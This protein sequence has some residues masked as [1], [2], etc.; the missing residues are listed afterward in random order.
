MRQPVFHSVLKH[1]F[2]FLIL[3]AG[4]SLA[5]AYF[6]HP[7]LAITDCSAASAPCAEDPIIGDNNLCNGCH[8]ITIV[9]GNRNGTDRPLTKSVASNRHVLDPRQ[10][11][12]RTTVTGMIG[13]GAGSGNCANKP[14]TEDKYDCAD[15]VVAYLNTNYSPTS[16]GP[17]MSSPS[18]SGVGTTTATLGWTT[19]AAATSCVLYGTPDP[20]EGGVLTGDTCNPSDP[21]YDANSAAM[22]QG[23]TVSLINLTPNTT[24]YAIH[25]STSATGTATFALAR[26]FKTLEE[27]G[28][29]PVTGG[30]GTIIS[31]AVGDYNGDTN[32]DLG[33]GVSIF[34]YVIAYL[35]NGLG[36][37]TEGQTLTNVGV[38]PLGITTGGVKAD[39]DGDNVADLAVANFGEV[40]GTVITNANVAIFLGTGAATPIPNPNNAFATTPVSTISLDASATAVAA[41]D[42]NKD[43][44]MDVAVATVSADSST[45]SV[46][47]FL[48][49]GAGH[50]AATPVATIPVRVKPPTVTVTG[51][52]PNPDC[53]SL[54]FNV[55]VAGTKL[56]DSAE[57]FLDDVTPLPVI[58]FAADET[59]AVLRIPAGTTAGPHTIV[60]HLGADSASGTFTVNPRAV[61][62][63]SIFPTS[64]T[65]GTGAGQQLT[66]SGLGF[67]VGSTVTVGS[68][69]GTTVAGTSATA[70]TPFVFVSTNTIRVWWPVTSMEPGLYDVSVTN[71]DACAGTV[72]AAGVFTVQ[73]TQPTV[74]SVSPTSVTYGVTLSREVR[75]SGSNFLVGSTVTLGTLT[76]TVVQGPA[77]ASAGNP[78]VWLSSGVLGVWW[79]NTSMPPGNYTATVTNPAASGGL[80]ASLGGA[81][82]VVAPQP[83]VISNPQ[84]VTYAVT[85]SKAISVSGSN[86]VLGARIDVG[87][88]SCVT[89]A[90]SV[91]TASVPCT[92]G[93]QSTLSFWWNNTAVPPG[94]YPLTVTNPLAAGGLSG[95][96]AGALT[97]LQAVPT[98]T[99]LSVASKIYGVD[100]GIAI[101]INGANFV[102][103]ATVTIDGLTGTTVPGSTA[104]VSVPFVFV[105]S[106]RLSFWWANTSLPPGV[107]PVQVTNPVSAG[108]QSATLAGGFTVV[109]PQPTVTSLSPTSKIYGVDTSIAITINGTNFVS[110]ATVSIGSLT[111]TTVPGSTATVSVP[112]VYV[113]SS[114]LSIWWVNTS[115][116]PGVYSVQV[117]N[118]VAA[119]GL[120]T[121]LAGGFT[122]I[123]PQP[124]VTSLTPASKTYGVDLGV[125]ITINGSNF[126]PG[127]T[128]S[129][130]SLTG[131]TVTG[132][133]A[134]AGVPFVHVTASRLSFWWANTSLPPGSYTVTVVNPVSA[135]GLSSALAGGFTVNQPQ[136][137]ISTLSLA[138]VTRGV[139]ASQSITI[140][141]TNFMLGDIITIQG[142]GGT[143]SGTTVSGSS[144]TSGVPFVYTTASQVK[145][146]WGNTSLPVGTYDVIVTSPAAAGGLSVTKVGGFVVN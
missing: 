55:T 25:R 113:T 98:V 13:K 42:F 11:D 31:L 41:A 140:S 94:T 83:T 8:S 54:P 82:T 68:L 78:F 77:G 100:L 90:G 53:L 73:P 91:A 132:S 47:V 97:V 10:V 121:T 134:T 139:T 3:F 126:M 6:S 30:P 52:T 7:A 79:A 137:T 72:S 136:P 127:A 102:S 114:R 12:W 85:A 24:Y 76:G 131:T 23:H 143:L 62:F 81:F 118:P 144:A 21:S 128:V 32:P 71:H 115:L 29:G 135:G 34:N 93:S 111:G 33:I 106:S 110:G 84:T 96:T 46:R 74:L 51:I 20:A 130:G 56:S 75:I 16:L 2:F 145:F 146:W 70:S 88:I 119:G 59:S 49:D 50:F 116:A 19:D 67:V 109:S 14:Q 40:N 60:A 63:S 101:S 123:A 38:K 120:S 36:G 61:T 141:G 26:K 124:T 108:G 4:L 86:F 80:S 5:D 17:I 125:A 92:F 95:S 57:F 48:G 87:G 104:T 9:G 37:F 65:Y 117:T 142:P 89:V 112:F 35:G 27:G 122:V 107:Y 22:T 18:L 103:G 44:K 138:S 64:V 69:S 58:S 66:I 45:G 133:S 1:A 28:G 129:V 39:F 43:G 105:S 15:K 99:S